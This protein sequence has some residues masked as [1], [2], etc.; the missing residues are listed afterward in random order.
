M[1][2]S[3]VHSTLGALVSAHHACLAGTDEAVEY[4]GVPVLGGGAAL[5]AKLQADAEA[6]DRWTLSR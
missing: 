6:A 5:D 1:E 4:D 2:A 3:V